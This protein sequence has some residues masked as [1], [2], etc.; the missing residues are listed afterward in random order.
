M[1]GPPS[2]KRAGGGAP[3]ASNTG[4]ARDS[5]SAAATAAGANPLRRPAEEED[6]PKIE[7]SETGDNLAYWEEDL[8]TATSWQDSLYSR[9]LK[10]IPDVAETYGEDPGAY[11]AWFK[12]QA[13]QMITDLERMVR[14]S[15]S[16]GQNQL[17]GGASLDT[18]E[19]MGYIYQMARMWLGNQDPRIVNA[20][21]A[22]DGVDRSRGS[23]G[24]GGGGRMTADQIRASFD[25]DQLAATARNIW[26]GTLLDDPKDARGMASAYVDAIVRN[27]DQKL[28]FEAFINKQAE[29]TARYASLYRN[30]PAAMS[31]QQ[32]LMPYL[33]SAQ[34]MA[35]P[36]EAVNIAVGGAQL[37]ADPNAFRSRLN[38]TNAVTTSA[39][40]ISSM[41]QRMT[42][43]KRVLKG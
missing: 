30:K 29:G 10:E 37:G 23:G 33:N 6:D 31:P 43:L 2:G 15:M 42:G 32:Y 35:R 40:F 26:Q 9:L 18:P 16:G 8:N 4:P 13:P 21:R 17:P 25:L 5:S 28:D 20:M 11:T 19:G 14:S 7:W 38:R 1:A 36:K 41:E 27:P 24:G 34:Q 39:P 22:E 3:T 12:R